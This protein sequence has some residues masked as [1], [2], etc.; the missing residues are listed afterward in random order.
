MEHN[1]DGDI[2]HA[3][4]DISIDGKLSSLHLSVDPAQY[5]LI[6]GLLAHNFGEP[7]DEFQSQLLPHIRDPRPQVIFCCWLIWS[8]S[9]FQKFVK[10]CGYVVLSGNTV[11]VLIISTFH[12]LF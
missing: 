8:A 2:T 12:C 3:V 7:L 11:S 10:L 4:P 1:L 9:H 5:Q 6:Y